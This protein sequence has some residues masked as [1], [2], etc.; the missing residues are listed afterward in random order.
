MITLSGTITIELQTS[1]SRSKVFPSQYTSAIKLN[2]MTHGVSYGWFEDTLYLNEFDIKD[3]NPITE[4]TEV[5]QVTLLIDTAL[6]RPPISELPK[7]IGTM[8]NPIALFEDLFITLKNLS[9]IINGLDTIFEVS[10]FSRNNL[11]KPLFTIQNYAT[12]TFNGCWFG[13]NVLNNTSLINVLDGSLI[14]LS[15][16]TIFSYNI[17]HGL[18]NIIFINST[19]NQP[20]AVQMILPKF[21]NNFGFFALIHSQQSNTI[22]IEHVFFVNNQNLFC[23]Y[24]GITNKYLFILD[25]TFQNGLHTS[26]M[27]EGLSEN[28]FIGN[29]IWENYQSVMSKSN[30][31]TYNEYIELTDVYAYDISDTAVII[32]K[33]HGVVRFIDC[34]FENIM[35]NDSVLIFIHINTLHIDSSTFKNFHTATGCML[36]DDTTAW[37]NNSTFLNN[38][39]YKNGGSGIT[40]R[41]I[42]SNAS[43]TQQI[44]I[45]N[46]TFARN[47]GYYHGALLFI[48]KSIDILPTK[49]YTS[50]RRE[51]NGNIP[52]TNFILFTY[53]N[54]DTSEI[55]KAITF[56]QLSQQNV[57]EANQQQN[58]GFDWAA[59]SKTDYFITFDSIVN[60]FNAICVEYN[61]GSGKTVINWTD[62]KNGANSL[63]VHL[64][65]K[66]VDDSN[67]TGCM[68]NPPG[69]K[70]QISTISRGSYCIGFYMI[71][72]DGEFEYHVHIKQLLKWKPTFIIVN[73]STFI[74]NT[75]ILGK[76]GS[77]S[78]TTNQ[79]V[80]E[81]I[82]VLINNTKFDSNYAFQGG[83]EVYQGLPCSN[84]M[85]S[86][87]MSVFQ[88]KNIQIR[89]TYPRNTFGSSILIE[90][91]APNIN[92]FIWDH[93]VF[94]SHLILVM[95]ETKSKHC[96]NGYGGFVLRGTNVYINNSTILYGCAYNGGCVWSHD[97]WLTLYKTT[98]S[99]C[100]ASNNGGG[101]YYSLS[102]QQHAYY[103][104]CFES[105]YS[106]FDENYAY[107]NGGGGYL[108]IHGVLSNISRQSC[109]KLFKVDF[110]ENEAHNGKGDPMYID[111]DSGDHDLLHAKPPLSIICE[112]KIC[113]KKPATNTLEIFCM[114]LDLFCIKF[115]TSESILYYEPISEIQLVRN[116]NNTL[117]VYCFDLFG[118]VLRTSQCKIDVE[119]V[120]VVIYD[121]SS[122]NNELNFVIRFGVMN[123]LNSSIIIRDQNNIAYPW[124][125]RLQIEPQN[126]PFKEYV[127]WVSFATV[128]LVVVCVSLYL[129]YKYKKYKDA[130]FMNKA[131]VLIIG[132]T[133]F[134]DISL[135]QPDDENNIAQL[136][137]LWSRKYHYD[138]CNCKNNATKA[139]VIEFIDS[140]TAK[141]ATN[142][143]KYKGVIVHIV[144]HGDN[145]RFMAS[146]GKYLD[147]DFIIHEFSDAAE[148]GKNSTLLKMIF[149]HSCRGNVNY[150]VKLSDDIEFNWDDSRCSWFDCPMF[151]IS[152]N[153]YN[154]ETPLIHK[155]E[156]KKKYSTIDMTSVNEDGKASD[157][158]DC[159]D[160]NFVIVYQNLKDRTTCPRGA[161]TASICETFGKNAK[162]G[163]RKRN[164]ES[165]LRELTGKL[166]IASGNAE[167]CESKMSLTRKFRCE[168]NVSILCCVIL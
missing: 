21:E 149:D 33:V 162:C 22:Y 144:T 99:E 71:A 53:D 115:L 139:D 83:A 147:L 142:S 16:Y 8:N 129:Y 77:V 152:S 64:K 49:T 78:I 167:I 130:Y 95:T 4:V 43:S 111:V 138:V 93:I 132:I 58:C 67:M 87:E 65:A 103:D 37:I 161:F 55:N 70:Y 42:D 133:T 168:P 102:S 84:Y 159:F 91:I 117:N 79:T 146:D 50:M 45:N 52:Q 157:D 66:M 62:I 47:R 104:H 18:S 127:W 100:I 2:N 89:D 92:G 134:N 108:A 109:V 3:T 163:K 90:N 128:F 60:P 31:I 10:Y 36:I 105:Y 158:S 85:Y 12:L 145:D 107:N 56:P 61:D 27:I 13:H 38:I 106:T 1:I 6:T 9:F 82:S 150:G 35:S 39:A 110:T 118:N 148:H 30:I 75:N 59:N 74:N 19:Y 72:N 141:I 156:I 14:L 124:T 44:V 25:S 88:L 17:G 86:T 73:D 24:Y 113:V 29:S 140:N 136:V 23:D 5:T 96:N 101:I 112:P 68:S 125:V 7:W 153:K 121:V 126:E 32:H 165:L 122:T 164:L 81:A 28:L 63:H 57:F 131:L 80:Y 26:L 34:T 76:G 116:A 119:G 123:A 98:I 151:A 120:N 97:A 154:E 114:S 11:T 155:T 143:Q 135:N 46:S 69:C 15:W 51:N 54:N 160:S 41:N 137:K 94:V 48:P 40:I 20:T 166:Q